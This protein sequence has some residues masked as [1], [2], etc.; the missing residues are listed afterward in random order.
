MTDLRNPVGCEEKYY[1][2]AWVHDLEKSPDFHPDLTLEN[3]REHPDFIC[4][5]E[6]KI[7]KV[8]LTASKT[9]KPD[10]TPKTVYHRVVVEDVMNEEAVVNIWKDDW[11]RFNEILKEGNLVRLRLQAPTP[12]FQTYTLENNRGAKSWIKKYA[13]KEDDYRVYLM[14]PPVVEV[15]KYQTDEETFDQLG[16]YAIGKEEHD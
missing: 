16:E 8:Q 6:L 13:N 2:F 9:K 5:V 1:G 10:G 12:P 4:P 3:L 11:E 15:E 7:K 14:K